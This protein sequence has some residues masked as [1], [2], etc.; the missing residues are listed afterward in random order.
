MKRIVV[1][2]LVVV[3]LAT[4][5]CASSTTSTVE[6]L[7]SNPLV[8]SLTSGLGLNATQAVGGA[9]ALLGSA[10]AKLSSDQWKSVTNAV[11]GSDAIVKE[12]KNL[13]GVTGN[14]GDVSSLGSTFSKLGI[15]SD[16][17]TQLVPALTGYVSKASPE[18][19]S[20]L[21]S[22]LR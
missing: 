6:S 2:S 19:G 14:F 20:M 17:A 22:V 10:Q 5:G 15:T 3:A 21:A 13:T 8:S 12:A 1:V 11:P 16:Q 7:A 4:L 9:G 18:V